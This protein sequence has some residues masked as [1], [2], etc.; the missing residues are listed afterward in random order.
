M[1]DTSV[2]LRRIGCRRCPVDPDLKVEHVLRRLRRAL[3]LLLSVVLAVTVTSCGDEEGTS[4]SSGGNSLDS[5][6][7]EGEPGEEPKV[8]FDGRLEVDELTTEVVSEGDGE[9][10]ADGDQ[11]FAHIWIGNGF[12]QKKSFSTYETAKP[13]LVT[14][15]KESLSEV[16][17]AGIED[18][19]IGSRVAVAAP[20]SKA[21]G[22]A[23]NPQLGIGNKDTVLVVVDLISTMAGEPSGAEKPAPAWAPELV[24][25]GEDITG[26]DFSGA[27]KPSDALRSATLIQGEG[28][29]A[30]KGQ[31]LYV[32]YLGQVHGA[33]KPFD[34]SYSKPQPAS[35]PI[36]VGQVVKGWDQ[37][38]VGT[39]IG[40]RVIM[41]IPPEL[42][43]GKKGNPQ[44]GIEGTDTLYFVVDVLGAV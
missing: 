8:E 20:A 21:F 29:E 41:A 39:K 25:D 16:F 9:T 32:N 6:S 35:F 3:P 19:K 38:L 14:V 11:V 27:P 22:E 23:G 28:P 30:E 26:L 24:L 12:T 1:P 31:T 5:V 17:R 4:G 43:Y 40:S 34:E 7:I 2:V 15:E 44:A 18:Q 42:G 33:K 10:V 13:E 36:G 37:V